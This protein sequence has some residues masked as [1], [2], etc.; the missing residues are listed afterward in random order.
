M[1]FILSFCA[2]F[3]TKNIAFVRVLENVN[4]KRKIYS[5]YFNDNIDIRYIRNRNAFNFDT[6]FSC[7]LFALFFPPT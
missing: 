2:S 7:V 6:T 4:A 5:F 1:F 3:K